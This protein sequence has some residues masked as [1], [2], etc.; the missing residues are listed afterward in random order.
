MNIRFNEFNLI[1]NNLLVINGANKSGKSKIL[2]TIEKGLNGELE[3]F[4]VNNNRVFKGDYNTIYIGDYN[5]FSTDFKLTKSN[6]FKKL[7][8]DDVL[9]TM[10][11]EDMLT[12]VN[13]IFNSIDQ[14]VN[15]LLENENLL[16]DIKFNINIDSIDKIIEK[17]TE[18][19]IEN[20]LLDDKITPRSVL[21][22]LLIDLAL[23]QAS[24]DNHEN[25]VILIDDV[26][27]S[28]DEKEIF[29]LIKILE[30][31]RIK[32]IVT[33]S[34]N[35]YSYV[36][37]KRCV[38]KLFNGI[39][40]NIVNIEGCI[41]E[42]VIRNEYNAKKSNDNFDSFYEENEYLI[43]EEDI[44]YFQNNIL[45]NLNYQIG[46][47]YS[48]NLNQDDFEEIISTKNDLEK[49]YLDII[50]K[51]LTNMIDQKSVDSIEERYQTDDVSDEV[52][53][54]VCG[55]L[56]GNREFIKSVVEKKPNI[57]MKILNN[58][59]ELAKKIKGSKAEGYV[60]FVKK[61]KTMWEDAYYSNESKLNET[62]YSTIGLKGAKNLS[63]NNNTRE[64]KK[65][66][67]RQKQV[68]D[69]HN[70]STDTLDNTNIKSKRETGWYKTKYGDWGTLI[71][72]KDAKLIKTLE[73]NK[74]YRLEEILK[75]DLL[76]QAYPEL[77]KNKSYYRKF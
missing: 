19:Y 70:N 64:Y 11:S 24:K 3:E 12:R 63:K 47:L 60:G 77:K 52:V 20:Y 65:P 40:N 41:K 34:R 50:Y 7:I 37:D 13:A 51:N 18:V 71:S 55:E 26:D 57:F 27:T 35:I 2:K 44:N 42:A 72:D 33:S 68:E 31:N 9:N 59:K 69:I 30:K 67:N 36:E 29:K 66:F 28:L 61:L 58:I 23:F 49:L 38:Y 25:T 74:T 46:L 45:P 76:Y 75:Y 54:Y 5:N 48:N 56:F 22:R 16:K 43:N 6:V 53:A 32:F 14:K 17:F 4:Y 10:N 15:R 39:L 1:F 73:P 62:K 21:R 8:Y